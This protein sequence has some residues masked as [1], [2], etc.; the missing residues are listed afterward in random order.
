MSGSGVPVGVPSARGPSGAQGPRHLSDEAWARAGELI[1]LY[2]E[3][4]SA[5]IPLCHLAQ[6]RT[7]GSLPTRWRTSPRWSGSPRPRCYGTATFYDMLHTEPV[8]THLVSICTNIAC[9]LDGAVELLEHA[10]D[11]LGVKAGGTTLDGVVTLEEAECLADCDR[12]PCVQVEPPFRR[13][14]RRRSPSTHWW[15]SCGRAVDRARSPRTARSTGLPETWASTADPGAG[16]RRAGR[17]GRGAGTPARPTHRR[18]AVRRDPEGVARD[19]HR[20][21][22]DRH[23]ASRVRRLV[24]PRALPRHRRLRRPAQGADHDPRGGRPRGRHGQPARPRRRRLPGR[25]QVGDAPQ[26]PGD[27]PGGE[28]GRER[29]GHLQGPP[30]HRAGPPPADR[31]RGHRRLRA[32]GDPGVHLHPRRVRARARAGPVRAQRRLR[33]RRGGRGHLRVGLLGRRGG[34]PGCRRLHLR[35]GDRAARVARGQARLPPDQAPVLPRGH[36]PL[37]RADRGQQRGDH[38]QPALDRR[39]TA[40][41]RSPP[42]ARDAPPAPGSSPWPATSTTPVSSSSRW[43]RPPSPT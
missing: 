43:S 12:A 2:P 11:S 1:A 35:R 24:H 13:R 39:A 6:E 37:R 36:R 21:S 22:E 19:P 15:P 32:A 3:P 10:E 17:D 8:G 29:A 33:P 23:R 40:A 25:P 18:R 31:R 27:L 20:R 5:L 38:V 42:S 14:A 30:A 41:P 34:P 28:R 4:R 26:E 16:R 9:L 7:G